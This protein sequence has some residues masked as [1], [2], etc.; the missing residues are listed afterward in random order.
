MIRNAPRHPLVRIGVVCASFLFATT[1][2]AQGQQQSARHARISELHEAGE[3]AAVI[4]EVEL[5]LQQAEGT[6][7][8]DSLHRYLYKYGHALR[9]VKGAEASIEGAERIME[10][11]RQ[12]A[13]APHELEALFDLSWIYYEAGEMRQCARV[14]SLAVGVADGSKEIS[15]A[16]RGR[17]RQY[18]AFDHSILG[19]HQ[20]CAKWAKEALEQYSQADDVPATQWAES[21][22]AVGS[23]NWHL[24]HIREAETNYMKAL[25]ILGTDTSEAA[26]GRKASAYGNLG[27]LWQGAGD[28][29]RARNAYDES[30]RTND[31]LIAITSDPFT[32][33]EAIVSRSRTY[34][35]LATVFFHLGDHGRARELLELARQD[36]SSVLEPGDPQLIAIQ[37]RFANLE[38]EAGNLDRA[39]VLANDFLISTE[40]AFGTRSESYRQASQLLGDIRRQ[41][42]DLAQA[43]SLFSCSIAAAPTGKDRDTDDILR[44]TLQSRALAREAAGRWNEA[45]TD[46]REARAIAVHTYDSTHYTVARA[47]LLLAEAHLGAG[48]PAAALVRVREAMRIVEE[49]SQALKADMV[50]HAF[51]G[52]ELLSDALYWKVIAERA[53]SGDTFN[54]EWNAD[55]DLA[56][57]SLSRNKAGVED[58]AGKLLL[59]ASQERL[60]DLAVDLAYEGRAVLG[61]TA[62]AQRILQLSEAHRSTLLKE[63][64]NAFKGIRFAGVPD[65][66]VARE[67]E[68]ITALAVTA[69]DRGSATAMHANDSAYHAFLVRLEKTHPTYFAL[70]YGEPTTTLADLR[71]H[72]LKPGRHLLSFSITDSSLHTLV[73]GHGDEHILRTSAAGLEK[74]VS[75]FNTAIAQRNVAEYVRLGHALYQRLIA[76]AAPYLTGTELLIIPDGPLHTIN[77]ETLLDAPSDR[78]GYKAHLLVHRY[79]MANLLSA[80]TAVRFAELARERTAATLALAPGFTDEVK[81][82]YR[83]QVADSTRL[84]KHFLSYVRQPFALRTAE[85]LGSVMRADLL[86]GMQAN[87][88]GFREAAPRYG[89]LH[90]GTHAEMNAKD[91]MYSRLVLSK[92]GEGVDPDQDG[93]LHAY[94]IYELDLRAQ[95]AVLTACETGAGA[96]D[97][98]GVRSIGY[99]FAYAGCPSLVMSL[100]NIDEKVSAEV[101]ERFYDY[102]AD[103]LPKHEALRKAKLDHLATATDEL[104]MPYYWAG[105]VLVGDVE[106]VGLSWWSRYRWWLVAGLLLL[107]AGTFWWRRR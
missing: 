44:S 67:Q 79:A 94:E 10:L 20:A 23:A 52:P 98:E 100:W 16:Q 25:E 31:H 83:A 59:V 30:L 89:I 18:L 69:A 71:R 57:T 22:T 55:L 64:L 56:I 82:R 48:D 28:L 72:L 17:A 85:G 1:G 106:P 41:Q 32:R 29:T 62:T 36:R 40:R 6:T 45:I 34:L 91:P 46:L 75:A 8:A 104:A 70:R 7:W 78:A 88:R 107:I 11:V 76:P 26:L 66:V 58:E 19:H 47:D 4:R 80:T 65:S 95:L 3:Y 102:L 43:D 93:Y 39:R 13:H 12:R 63:R 51:P 38:V 15:Y 21:Y 99:S 90:L 101:I 27:V 77:F 35:N 33:E 105:L 81:Q 53:M 61:T 54:K 68:L 97:G 73:I 50:P 24:G 96:T 42:G 2:H 14:D 87:E 74:E 86:L 37:Q 49:R 92:D 9:R 103:G 60:F 84:D 5:Q